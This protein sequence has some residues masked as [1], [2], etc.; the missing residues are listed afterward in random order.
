MLGPAVPAQRPLPDSVFGL[1]PFESI[2]VNNCR[3]DQGRKH[4][5][6]EDESGLCHMSVRY[7]QSDISV[8]VSFPECQSA[9][10]NVVV[11]HLPHPDRLSRHVRAMV[12]APAP[13]Q[14]SAPQ[15]RNEARH[16]PRRYPVL[17]LFG[18]RLPRPN[19]S[20]RGSLAAPMARCAVALRYECVAALQ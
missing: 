16:V 14:C 20:Q 4:R 2:G 19:A 18:V 11:A 9:T 3:A 5:G 10:G 8:K 13:G 6:K 12:L 15:Q 1:T 17:R 7:L